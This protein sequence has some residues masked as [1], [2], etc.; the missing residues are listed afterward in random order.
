MSD[1][2]RLESNI[3]KSLKVHEDPSEQFKNHRGSLLRRF[4][5]RVISEAHLDLDGVIISV[6]DPR[7]PKQMTFIRQFVLH[8]LW[9]FNRCLKEH[10]YFAMPKLVP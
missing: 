2:L 6:S 4:T 8:K 9:S 10:S 5:G 1:E 7:W 3:A